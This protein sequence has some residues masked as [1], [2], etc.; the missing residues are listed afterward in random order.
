[1]SLLSLD[2]IATAAEAKGFKVYRYLLGRG[3]NLLEIIPPDY[4]GPTAYYHEGSWYA[5]GES[6]HVS[7]RPSLGYGYNDFFFGPWHEGH[8]QSDDYSVVKLFEHPAMQ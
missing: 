4:K 3:G 7:D 5:C 1:M 6:L 8:T 2:A